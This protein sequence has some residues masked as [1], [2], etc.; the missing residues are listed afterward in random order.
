[1][2]YRKFG[3]TDL[4]VSEIGFGAW[5]IGGPAEVGGIPIG[6]GRTDD[7]ESIAAI[8]QALDLGI[9]FFD[10]AD[11]YGLG[12]SEELLGKELMHE[13]QIFL[14]SKVGQKPGMANEILEDYT[15]SYIIQA[16]ENTLRRLRRGYLD[17]YQL[18]TAKLEDL[19]KGDAIP[20]MEQ[21]QRDGKIRYWGTSLS[22]F[23]AFPEAT[24]LLKQGKGQGLQIAFNL[25]NQLSLSIMK[26]AKEEKMGIVARMPLQF[27]LLS[28]KFSPSTKFH[29]DD[30]R[31]FRLT[32][33]VIEVTEALLQPVW[34]LLSKYQTTKVGLSLSFILSHSEVS[35]VIPG[36]RNREQVINN[37]QGVVPILREDREEIQRFFQEKQHKLMPLLQAAG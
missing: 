16:C 19:K 29:E 11:F 9:N 12:H 6:W 32:K 31:S 30:H 24:Y 36:M 34:A 28:G 23:N 17:Y 13:D 21:L 35:T 8:R 14:A 1:M 4:L 2:N 26:Q 20:A 10:T 22:T 37:V 18:H 15:Y 7:Q 5:A 25:I 27:G 33:E 3:E